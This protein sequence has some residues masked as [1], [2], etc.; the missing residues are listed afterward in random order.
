MVMDI[1]ALVIQATII[2]AMATLQDESVELAITIDEEVVE[3]AINL[4]SK[5]A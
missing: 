2:M 3:W 4:V 1:V 5:L